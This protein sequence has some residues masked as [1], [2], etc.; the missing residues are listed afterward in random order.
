MLTRMSTS[1]PLPFQDRPER[2]IYTVSRLNRE[3]RQLLERGMAALWIEGEVSNFTQHTSGNW[4]FTLKDRNAQV[5][6]VMWKANRQGSSFTPRV[7][8]QIVA[9]VRVT[10]YET[11]GQYQLSVER[12][13]EAGLGALQRAFDVLKERLA[14]EGLFAAERKRPLPRIPRRIGVVT[15]PSGAALRDVIHVL[16]RRFPPVAILIYPT[17]VQGAAAAPR[18]VEALALASARRECD[19]VI[20][21]RGGGS[22]ED[23][24]AFNDER[25]ARAIVAS[26][27]PVVSGVG[28][29][30]D[31]TIADFA[32]DV[33]APTPSAA[34][35]LVVPDCA[36]CLARVSRT[37]DRLRV[38]MARELRAAGVRCAAAGLRLK[39]ADP[40]ARLLQRQ[41][42]LD[43]LSQRLIGAVRAGLHHD[44]RHL[45]DA[46]AALVRM[47]PEGRVREY[48]ARHAVLTGRLQHALRERLASA[49]HR[50]GLAQR[51]LHT[52]SPLATLARGFAVITR[53]ADGALLT[54]AAH[55]KTGEEIDALMSDGRFRARVIGV[56]A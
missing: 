13:E 9:R 41:Q 51:T 50:L 25:V 16:A 14:A 15:S 37:S 48:C 23:L 3:V 52:V 32:A 6:C 1:L 47:S 2:T 43:D 33:R 46:I 40:S 35:E 5:S 31:F 49:A 20:L 12:L 28:H 21:A 10:L 26:A 54:Q 11:R 17:P 56:K 27:I 24:W 4:Y 18:I 53:A 44:E 19:V 55:V 39:L 45:S 29:E 34:A 8:Q 38:A 36:E 7:G 30:I 22:L 42:R